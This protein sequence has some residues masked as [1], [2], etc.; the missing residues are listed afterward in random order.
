[1]KKQNKKTA[2]KQDG[3]VPVQRLNIHEWI[4]TTLGRKVMQKK[5]KNKLHF[6][7]LLVIQSAGV[8]AARDDSPLQI[9]DWISSVG[10]N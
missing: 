7:Y 1:M 4:V 8:G 5:K 9:H 6:T 3:A 2:M 10:P